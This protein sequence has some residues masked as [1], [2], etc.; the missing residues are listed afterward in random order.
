MSIL[1]QA[2]FWRSKHDAE[3]LPTPAFVAPFAG[4]LGANQEF[5]LDKDNCVHL[6]LLQKFPDAAPWIPIRDAISLRH[7]LQ[8]ELWRA[9]TIEAVGQ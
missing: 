5:S 6:E 9:A 4:R 8:P 3:R 1:P 2:K 7:I